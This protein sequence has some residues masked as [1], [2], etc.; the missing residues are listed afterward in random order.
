MTTFNYPDGPIVLESTGELYQVARFQGRFVSIMSLANY[1]YDLQTLLVSFEDFVSP[2]AQL[3]YVREDEGAVSFN[4][5]L[6]LPGYIIGSPRMR[7]HNYTYPTTFGLPDGRMAQRFSRVALEVPIQRPRFTYS[8][9]LLLPI[10]CVVLCAGLMFLLRP[11][12][13]DCRFSIG[14]TALLTIV[15][16][17]ITLNNDLPDVSYL[18]L[19][20]KLY[21]LSYLFVLSGLSVVVVTTHLLDLQTPENVQKAANINHTC[22]VGF[23]VTFVVLEILLIA[24]AIVGG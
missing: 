13:V 9:K 11:S 20:D 1:P 2:S 7:I 17:Q 24:W 12:Y 21:I 16:L 19:M 10:N 22:M 3:V 5:D 15:A 8:L 6:T 14:I 23:G 4:P 18:V